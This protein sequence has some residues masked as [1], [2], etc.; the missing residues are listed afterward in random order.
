VQKMFRGGWR[1]EKE[2]KRMSVEKMEQSIETLGETKGV[3][4][5]WPR[6]VGQKE[7][8]HYL[9]KKQYTSLNGGSGGGC[10]CGEPLKNQEKIKR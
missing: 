4:G 5:S 2:S 9:V 1:E 10:L 8:W 7:T 6:W 3:I